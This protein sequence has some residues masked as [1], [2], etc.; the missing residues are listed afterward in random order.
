PSS[1]DHDQG[2]PKPWRLALAPIAFF[3]RN[4]V[5][6]LIPSAPASAIKSAD[7]RGPRA[8]FSLSQATASSAASGSGPR[9]L[10]GGA[11]ASSAVIVTGSTYQ[12]TTGALF[13]P[14]GRIVYAK[15]S[16]S[17]ARLFFT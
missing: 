6:S 11:R 17:G 10:C 7:S 8:S 12:L 3:A 15:P 1:R 2:P 4:N 9:F 5:R 16:V 13:F 14:S